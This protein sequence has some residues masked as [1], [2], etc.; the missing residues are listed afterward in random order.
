MGEKIEKLA[1]YTS[2]KYIENAIN[3]GIYASHITAVNDPF[4][5]EGVKYPDEYRICCMTNS[6]KQMIMWAY[7]TNH[8]GCLIE[9]D[10]SHCIELHNDLIRPVKYEE[11]LRN[12]RYEMTPAEVFESLYTKSKEWKHENEYR[13][14][15]YSESADENIWT[16]VDGEVYLKAKV[17]KIVF[18]LFAEKDEK[19]IC[20]LRKLREINQSREMNSIPLIE[21]TKCRLNRN[22]YGLT[23]DKQFD[24]IKELKRRNG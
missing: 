13:A 23:E 16:I 2:L 1:K 6:A 9:Y 24:Y 5:N 20:V 18:G 4:E 12:S 21:V 7:Y 17:T 11:S 14:A 15:Y 22:N 19:Y 3:Y 10:V 8:R